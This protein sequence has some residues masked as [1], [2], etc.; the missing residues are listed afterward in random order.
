MY[1]DGVRFCDV[2][3]YETHFEA[4]TTSETVQ[5]FDAEAFID[6]LYARNVLPAW[7]PRHTIT[8]VAGPDT[9]TT[10]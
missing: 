6:S 5:T 7:V 8:V 1:G 10:L 2:F 9:A 4:R 3:A